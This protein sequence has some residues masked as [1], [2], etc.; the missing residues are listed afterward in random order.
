MR[1][2]SHRRLAVLSAT[3]VVLLGASFAAEWAPS[4][5]LAALSAPVVV[6]VAAP[7]RRDAAG[8]P[9]I[10]T[11][12]WSRTP[13][14]SAT[15][16]VALL[17]G[18]GIRVPPVTP[19]PWSSRGS[20]R[21][22]RGTARAIGLVFV[23]LAAALVAARDRV[24]YDCGKLLTWSEPACGSRVEVTADD[25]GVLAAVAASVVCAATVLRRGA[26]SRRQLAFAWAS[27]VAGNGSDRSDPT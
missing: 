27:R 23:A 24:E 16:L 3:V 6:V 25:L 20:S 17:P 7:A 5:G 4:A 18:V 15:G 12:P 8:A 10:P 9:A 21:L 26:R 11:A 1:A 2:W 19:V 22:P 14:A 13:V